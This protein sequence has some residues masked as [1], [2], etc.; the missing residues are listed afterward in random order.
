M[1]PAQLHGYIHQR[2]IKLAVEGGKSEAEADALADAESPRLAVDAATAIQAAI[3]ADEDK[4]TQFLQAWQGG[5]YEQV[6]TWIN[7]LL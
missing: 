1:N 5:V 2:I 4:Q 6:D 7:D 3:E